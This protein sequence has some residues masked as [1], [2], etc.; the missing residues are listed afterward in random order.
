MTTTIRL[1]ASAGCALALA[2]GATPA[3]AQTVD[4]IVAFGDS[5]ADDGNLFELI[6]I[7]RPAPYPQGRFSDSTN[8]VDTMSQILQVPVANFAI[9]GAFT[10]N[11]NINGPGIPG[12]VTEYQSFLAGGG[13]A[14]FPRVS[15]TFNANDLLVISIGGNDARAYERSQGL[16]PS[17]AQ[18]TAL[19]AGVPAQATAR[20]AETT[21][22]LN[23]LIGAGA[24][25]IT[26]LAGDVGRLP[27]VNGLA[28]AQVGSAYATAYNNGMRAQLATY[29]GQGVIVNY[30]DLNRIG[31]RVQ[32]NLSSYG[33]IS[34]G[35][36]PLACAAN[37][38]VA[39]QYLFYV[40]QV[41]LTSRGFEIVGQY[42]ARQVE[43][44]LHF[45]AQ[46]EIGLQAARNFGNSMLSRLDLSSA[47]FGSGHSG[48]NFFFSGNIAQSDTERTQT[49][50]A[51]D[52]ETKAAT[53]GVEYDLASGIIVGAA[54]SYTRGDADFISGTGRAQADGWQVGAYAGWEGGGA[55]VQGYAGW[56]RLDYEIERD[57]VIDTILATADGDTMVAGAEA[58]YLL[59]LG[60]LSVGPVVGLRY[61]RAEIDA[62][63]ETGDP[64]LTLNVSDQRLTSLTG[65]AGIEARGSIQ[66]GGIAIQPYAAAAIEREFEGD[67]RSMTYA[68]TAAPEIVNTWN[69]PGRSHDAYGRLTGGV[70][71]ALGS[72]IALQV[73]ATGTLEREDGNDFAGSL[74]L[75]LGF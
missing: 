55:F 29:A 57:A 34:A 69:M 56:G 16:N 23:A 72:S 13:P 35:A 24:Q 44:P 25:N 53:G 43:A 6:G 14:A 52:A 38:D 5:Y 28:I 8:F 30:V 4:R 50:L 73:Q 49:S 12:F 46:G 74:A 67:A 27:E 20:I 40:D 54:A 45:E 36:C 60:G 62:Y 65:S 58:G 1:L 42:A 47:R 37:P 70:N 7:P 17:Q 22:G 64:V 9:G 11:G 59:P 26:F 68:L 19:L 71:L 63:T 18:I 31:D 48:L 32:A 75:R 2:A 10:G 15:G 61:A 33:L 51:Y 3:S 66:G 41:H 39:R 21:T